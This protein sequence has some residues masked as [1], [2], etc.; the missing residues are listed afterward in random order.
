MSNQ[1][2]AL[3]HTQTTLDRSYLLAGLVM[4]QYSPGK[5][6]EDGW[7]EGSLSFTA[8]VAAS[9]IQTRM[10]SFHE[11]TKKICIVCILCAV[12]YLNLL[13]FIFHHLS[14]F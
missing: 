3:G 4:P 9:A 2:E 11:R 12:E 10:R 1:D 6:E 7:A 13:I 5:A 14:T 8:Q